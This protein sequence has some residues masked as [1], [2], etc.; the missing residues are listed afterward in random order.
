M[1]VILSGS[2]WKLGEGGNFLE[3]FMNDFRSYLSRIYR[4]NSISSVVSPPENAVVG[5]GLLFGLYFSLDVVFPF[6]RI[7]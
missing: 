6:A 1:A 3:A 5:G 4:S 7:A 2:R